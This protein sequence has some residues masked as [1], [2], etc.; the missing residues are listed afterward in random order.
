M[1]IYSYGLVSSASFF[2]DYLDRLRDASRIIRCDEED[3]EGF[4]L[5][6]LSEEEEMAYEEEDDYRKSLGYGEECF[7]QDLEEEAKFCE[8]YGES[9]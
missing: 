1:N 3:E 2:K 4:S 9:L 7:S 6:K 5:Q 8:H